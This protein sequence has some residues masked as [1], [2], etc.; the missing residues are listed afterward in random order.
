MVTRQSADPTALGNTT[1]RPP[2]Y[3]VNYANGVPINSTSNPLA[4]VQSIMDTF[5]GPQ[6]TLLGQQLARQYDQ[7]GMVGADVDYRTGAIKRDTDLARQG[8]GLQREGLGL[9][10]RAL[11][12][13]AGLAQGQRANLDK[14][15]GILSKQYGLEGE[16]LDNVLGQ[17]GIDEAKLKDMAKRQTFDLRSGLTARGAFNT[18]ANERGTG[19]I[20]RDLLYGL[21]GINN[22]RDAASIANRRALLGLDEKGIGYDNQELGLNARLAGIGVDMDR[23]GLS[24]RKLGLDEQGLANSL[25]DG[26]RQIGLDGF[27]S[28]NGLLDAIG[29]T[30]TQ[31]A[32]LATTILQQIIGYSDLPADVIAELTRALGITAPTTAAPSRN[33]GPGYEQ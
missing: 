26:L 27:M 11:G 10:R 5:Y 6:Q 7:L 33:Q 13:D 2:N 8:I 18:V 31:Q 32:Q 17:L 3:A 30:N 16:E 28:V 1:Y 20:D 4:G 22:Q 25:E 19:R 15:R 9:D 21:G 12:I 29:G 24:E 23:I 14:L